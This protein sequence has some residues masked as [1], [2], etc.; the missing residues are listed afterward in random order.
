VLTDTPTLRVASKAY[1]PTTKRVPIAKAS[2][3]GIEIGLIYHAGSMDHKILALE[4]LPEIPLGQR[5]IKLCDSHLD[6]QLRRRKS[7]PRGRNVL[8]F[9]RG[10]FEAMGRGQNNP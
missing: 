3:R 4:Q 7:R 9:L 8:V 5:S 1:H 6:A 10:D 2:P